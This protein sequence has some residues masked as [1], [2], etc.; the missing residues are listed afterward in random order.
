MSQAHYVLC[1]TNP[2]HGPAVAAVRHPS[3]FKDWPV[4]KLCLDAVLDRCDDHPEHEPSRLRWAWD[5]GTR[6][7]PIHRWSAVLCEGW[8]EDE[9]H[10]FRRGTD[11]Y[12]DLARRLTTEHRA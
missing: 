10:L 3:S 12:S 11:S 2:A 1:A 6:W 4:C 5:A 7:C 9:H 8:S